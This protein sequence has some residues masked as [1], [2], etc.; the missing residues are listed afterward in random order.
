MET[1]ATRLWKRLNREERTS[2]ARHFFQ[3]PPQEVLGSAL[4]A[5][6]KARKIRPQVART[7]PPE[8]QAKTLAAIS[9]L[10]EPLAASLLVALHLGDRRPMLATFLDAV[11]LP[12]EDG[13]LKDDEDASGPLAEESARKGVAALVAAYPRPWVELY[14]NVLFIQDPARWAVLEQSLDWM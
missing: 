14:M 10:G 6:V 5:I 12:H 11:G 2:A 1:T 7:L 8:D 4:G 13:L 9:D 3:E